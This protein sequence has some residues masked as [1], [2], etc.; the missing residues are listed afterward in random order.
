MTERKRLTSRLRT[1]LRKSTTRRHF[2]AS[3]AKAGVGVAAAWPFVLTPGKAKAAA[4]IRYA[5]DGGRTGIGRGE[6]YIKPFMKK[7]GIEVKTYIGSN[8]LAKIKAMVKT[9]NLEFDMANDAGTTALAASKEGLLEK[10]D[11]SKLDLSRHAIPSWIWDDTVAWEYYSGGIGYN[12][13]TTKDEEAPPSWADYWDVNKYP[14]RRGFRTR[15]NET[16]EQALMADGIAPK[17]LYPLD[18]DRAFKSLDRIKPHVK[19]WISQTAKTIEHLQTKELDYTFTYSGRVMVAKS[20]GFPL[21]FNFDIPISSPQNVW[22]LKGA[23]NYDSVIKLCDWF[24][25]WEPGVKWFTKFIGYG[26][27]DSVTM[28]KLSAEVKAKLPSLDNEKACWTDVSWWG[29]NLA[30]MTKRYKKWQIT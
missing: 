19:I 30:D 29:D 14:G 26:P 27:T 12:T 1:R 10:L 17:D 9:G 3:T 4:V 16:M 13:D 18:I 25:N 22:I 2:L 5:D 6:F 28:D 7:T 20:E 24:L 11:K 23:Q 8:T 15:P 21:G